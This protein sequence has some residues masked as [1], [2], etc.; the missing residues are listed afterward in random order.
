MTPVSEHILNALPLDA[1]ERRAL[2]ETLADWR[3]EA[4]EAR[5]GWDRCRAGI[6][7]A[8]SVLF[9]VA[10]IIAAGARQRSAWR[11][12]MTTAMMAAGGAAL[13]LP[14]APLAGESGLAHA[15]R[16]GALVPGL[17]CLSLPVSIAVRPLRQRNHPAPFLAISVTGILVMTALIGWI[18]PASNQFYRTATYALVVPDASRLLIPGLSERSLPDLAWTALGIWNIDEAPYATAILSMRLALIAAV[19]ACCL[20]GIRARQL[21]K[22]RSLEA[23]APM[24]AMAGLF[25][26]AAAAFGTAGLLA[27]L[28]DVSSNELHLW[29]FSV[30]GIALA[31][32]VSMWTRERSAVASP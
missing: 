16:V 19:P 7:G 32:G 15:V 17:M 29:L 23:A 4:A 2:D 26:V 18:V 22:G 27:A 25:I 14:W 10:A 6:T 9:V 12:V 28:V 5:R 3:H 1:R 21:V 31:L 30:W 11:D 20:I 24:L 8:L 13:F